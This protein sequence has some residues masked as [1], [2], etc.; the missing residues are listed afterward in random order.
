MNLA[1]AP[2][3]RFEAH[4]I[5]VMRENFI[6]CNVLCQFDMIVEWLWTNNTAALASPRA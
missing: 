2:E 4:P 5:V 3:H 1:D 6:S